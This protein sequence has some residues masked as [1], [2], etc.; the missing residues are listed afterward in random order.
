MAE[1]LQPEIFVLNQALDAL[2]RLFG[3]ERKHIERSLEAMCMHD[4]QADPFARG[5]YS[6]SAT[7]GLGA[8]EELA[9][10]VLK[11]LWFSPA[12]RLTVTGITALFME[13]GRRQAGR[14]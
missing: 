4:W 11:V 7:G 6:Y 14:H 9:R 1:Q 8:Q 10:P 13:P 12:K 5:S 2:T 3:I